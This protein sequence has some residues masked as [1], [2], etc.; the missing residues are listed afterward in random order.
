MDRRERTEVSS[1]LLP[2]SGEA[3][4][5]WGKCLFSLLSVIE[6]SHMQTW[7]PDYS[8]VALACGLEQIP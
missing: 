4:V 7:E 8:C 1:V 6:H 3:A 5:G 2:W